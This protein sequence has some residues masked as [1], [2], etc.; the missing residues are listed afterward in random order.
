MQHIAQQLNALLDQHLEQ[1]H[2]LP[3]EKM[4][5]KTSPTK[6]SKRQ[7][8]GHL[9][10]SAHSNIRR[11]VVAQYEVEPFIVYNQDKW[12]EIVNYQEWDDRPIIDLWYALNK[13]FC[14][15]LVNTSPEMSAR[16][17]RTQEMHTLDWLASD[18]LLHLRHHLHQVLDL[19]PVPYPAV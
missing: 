12:V 4:S 8:M 10:D 15:I 14:R 7:I 19:E 5:K 16:K 11:M 13:Q 18:Y 1:L 3:Y 9:V 17:C 6:W 2:A